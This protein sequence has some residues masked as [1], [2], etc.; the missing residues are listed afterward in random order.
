LK[1]ILVFSL[2]GPTCIRSGAW[3]GGHFQYR[4]HRTKRNKALCRLVHQ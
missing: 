3:E 2:F 1:I 4:P